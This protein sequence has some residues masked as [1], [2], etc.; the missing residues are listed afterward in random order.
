MCSE[1]GS[2]G[3]VFNKTEDNFVCLGGANS[4]VRERHS[5][6][7]IDSYYDR[8]CYVIDNVWIS[9]FGSLIDTTSFVSKLFIN[10]KNQP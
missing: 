6:S 10:I 2:I 7:K 1:E 3:T 9:S 4:F 8:K 5:R